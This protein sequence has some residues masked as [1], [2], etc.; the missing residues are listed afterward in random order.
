[1]ADEIISMRGGEKLTAYLRKLAERMGSGGA[2]K[3]GFLQ[4]KTYPANSKGKSLSVA[5][6]AFWNNFGTSRTRARPFFSNTVKDLIPT[7]GARMAKIAKATNYDTHQTLAL[8]GTGIKD[9]I[10][11]SIAEW[12]ADNAPRTVDAKGFNKGLVHQGIMQRSVDFE[13]DS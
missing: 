4:D 8:V 13:V 1:M 9:R 6:V 5:Q 7:L 10:V 12:P 3:V 11:R 2:V